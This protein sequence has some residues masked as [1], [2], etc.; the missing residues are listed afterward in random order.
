MHNYDSN[1]GNINNSDS[2]L[3]GLGEG[4]VD[5]CSPRLEAGRE[6]PM[7]PHFGIRKATLTALAVLILGGVGAVAALDPGSHADYTIRSSHLNNGSQVASAATPAGV[8]TP[9]TR[10][11]PVV[12]RPAGLSRAKPVPLVIALHASGGFPATFEATSGLDAVADQHGFVVAYLGSVAPASP[13]WLLVDMPQNLAYI[14]AEIKSL[15]ASQNIDPRR[16]YVTGFSAGATMAF[17]VGCRLSRQVD[18]IAPVS[19]AMRFTD[20][21]RVSHPVSEL[22]VI[23]T[24]DAIPIDGTTRLLSDAQVATRWRTFDGCTSHSTTVVRGPAE[25]HEW[26]RCKGTSGVALDVIHEGTHQWPAPAALGTDSQFPAAQAVW[27][28]FAAHP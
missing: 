28:F 18:G 22:E 16:V 27:A 19:A 14:S 20:R 12:H 24:K 21:C 4:V 7:T 9:G 2:S 25:E 17:F 1:Y 8:A 15:T 11:Q 23:G 26:G 3:T 6:A 13:A 5:G 10:P